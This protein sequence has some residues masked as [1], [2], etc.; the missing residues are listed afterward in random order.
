MLVMVRD[1][2][3]EQNVKTVSFLNHTVLTPIRYRHRDLGNELGYPESRYR[4]GFVY[5]RIPGRRWYI[6]VCLCLRSN[7]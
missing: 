6:G 7:L 1:K 4:C 3:L 2:C 5:A